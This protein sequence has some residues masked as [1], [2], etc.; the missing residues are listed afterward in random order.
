M[1]KFLSFNSE[2]RFL[3]I[4]DAALLQ[5]SRGRFAFF[6]LFDRLMKIVSIWSRLYHLQLE[7][8]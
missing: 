2:D 1:R 3:L 4:A 6:D 8:L 5:G 7:F